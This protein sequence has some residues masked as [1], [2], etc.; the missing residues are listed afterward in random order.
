MDN[1]FLYFLCIGF[2]AQLVD[3]ALGMA[4]GVTS[5]TFLLSLGIPPAAASASV[6]AAEVFTTGTSGLSHLYFRNV[7]TK[8]LKK[9]LLPGVAGAVLGAL[10]LTLLPLRPI[11]LLVALYLALMGGLIL[12]RALRPRPP[13]D[14]PPPRLGGLGFAGGF[15]DAMGGGGWG[16]I[17]T[18]T[19]VARGGTPRFVVGSVNLAEFFV[20]LAAS[21]TFFLTIGFS[22][23]TIILGLVVGG[24]LAAPLAAVICRKIPTR[25]FM[26]LIGLLIIVLALRAAVHV[27]LLLE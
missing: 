18:S 15:L 17:V 25:A 23:G 12:T 1:E 13:S 5:T 24:A 6:H 11:R 8:V 19:L 16:P 7:D 26:V 9:L 20:A 14:T 21:V 22:H 3:G 4:Y 2:L 10:F 27:L